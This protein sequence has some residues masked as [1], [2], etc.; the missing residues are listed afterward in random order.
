MASPCPQGYG[1]RA[2]GADDQDLLAFSALRPFGET[3][4]ENGR[5]PG[6]WFH[7]DAERWLKHVRKS[8]NR[9]CDQDMLKQIL[10]GYLTSSI[11]LK[12]RVG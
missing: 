1:F 7:R 2:Q 12:R 6:A 9:F 10:A 3:E 8:G 11:G 5:R 4:K